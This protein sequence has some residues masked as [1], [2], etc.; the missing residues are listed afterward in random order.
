M[1]CRVMIDQGEYLQQRGGF[2]WGRCERYE[3][4]VFD[5]HDD[6]CEAI[7]ALG[8]QSIVRQIETCDD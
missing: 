1:Y 6:A 8:V 3:A 4:T 5:S 7:K 2:D